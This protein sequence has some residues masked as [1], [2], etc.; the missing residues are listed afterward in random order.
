MAANRMDSIRIGY[1]PKNSII[2]EILYFFTLKV[3]KN[4][5]SLH[6]A[7]L[8]QSCPVREEMLWTN[9]FSDFELTQ[10]RIICYLANAFYLI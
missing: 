5:S 10:R 2:E 6:T 8:I 3:V 7:K 1:V 4:V 9:F